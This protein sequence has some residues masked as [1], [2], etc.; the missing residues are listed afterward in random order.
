MTQPDF[1]SAKGF[2][3]MNATYNAKKTPGAL[4]KM[5]RRTRKGLKEVS[6]WNAVDR[7]LSRQ[8]FTVGVTFDKETGKI[9][10]AEKEQEKE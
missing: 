9:I 8:S 5:P 7:R 10:S 1:D 4:E 2:Y 3:W 6:Y